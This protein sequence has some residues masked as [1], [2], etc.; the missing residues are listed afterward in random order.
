MVRNP[1]F[2]RCSTLLAERHADRKEPEIAR[3]QSFQSAGEIGFIQTD[4]RLHESDIDDE[5]RR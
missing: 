5:A 2:D 1:Q 4:E 3:C